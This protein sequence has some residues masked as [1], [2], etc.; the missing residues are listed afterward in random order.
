MEDE[1]PEQH[2]LD[3]HER[4]LRVYE[5]PRWRS[6]MDPV[7]V[8]VSTILSQNTNDVN[9]DRAFQRLRERFP[10]WETVRDADVESVKDA[11]RVAGLAN[12]KAPTIQRALEYMTVQRGELSLDFL[13]DMPVT[14]AKSWLT[15]I[16]GVGPKTAAIVLLFSLGLPAFLVDTH[17]HRVTRRLALIGPKVSRE[18]AHEILEALLAEEV[19]Y[20]FHLNIIRHGRQVCLARNPRCEVCVLEDVC[21]YYRT[22]SIQN[23]SRR[24]GKSP[25]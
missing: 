4:L 23:R 5:E 14:E 24:I 7:S 16:N 22:R 18:Q 1:Q 21:D 11:I 9:R 20:A 3:I 6:C 13:K 17:V 19:Y 2:A 8:L 12:R 25:L 10:T 15:A